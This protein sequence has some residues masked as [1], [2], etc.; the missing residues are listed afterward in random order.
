M[1]LCLPI[2]LCIYAAQC[3]TIFDFYW[4]WSSRRVVSQKCVSNSTMYIH[5]FFYLSGTRC[6]SF[7]FYLVDIILNYWKRIVTVFDIVHLLKCILTCIN[8][9]INKSKNKK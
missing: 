4:S 2:Y 1:L 8:I 9:D 3:F 6:A 7:S 5:D